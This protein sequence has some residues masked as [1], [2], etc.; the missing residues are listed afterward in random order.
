MC[1]Q[2]GEGQR[3]TTD[4]DK[5]PCSAASDC[6]TNMNSNS[7][8]DSK[9]AP[10][11]E[12]SAGVW[13]KWTYGYMGRILS[14]SFQR[15]KQRQQQQEEDSTPPLL[16]HDDIYAVPDRL[17]SQ[18]L[19]QAF[20]S[21]YKRQL[22]RQPTHER[23]LLWALWKL[24]AP[25][26]VPA[27]VCQLVSIICQ[28]AVPLIVRQLLQQVEENPAQPVDLWPCFCILA[29]L[30]VYGMTN[31][32]QRHLA[33]QAGITLR[34]TVL[35]VLYEHILTL[36]PQ[37]RA[38]VTT[39]QVTNLVAVDTQKLYEV[40]QEGHLLWALPLAILLVTICLVTILGPVSLVGIAVLVSLVPL[41]Q[42]ITASMLRLRGQRV[43]CTDERIATTHALLQGI[44][45]T[46]LNH[47]EQQYERT[48]T[49]V[50]NQEL[51]WLARETAVWATTLS[52]S[53]LSAAFAAASTFAVYVLVD[54]THILTAALSFSVFLLFSALRFP[55]NYAGRLMGRL[56][57]ARSSI[58]RLSAFL[59]RPARPWQDEDDETNEQHFIRSHTNING[60]PPLTVRQG[61][62]AIG[63]SVHSK[64]SDDSSE[65]DDDNNKPAF[66]VS[67]FDFSVEKG[68]VL[69]CCGPVGSGKS[70]LIQGILG[71]A[72]AASPATQ[73][74][75]AGS[76][77]LVPQTPF[78]LNDTV[79]ENILFGRPYDP[80]VY[81]Q[82]V[83][84]CCLGPD[85]AG[86]GPTRD[87]TE[88]GERG[89]TLSG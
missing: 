37:G 48:V 27:G 28:V 34:A 1:R 82:V 60:R 45:V 56:A 24:A 55:I 62:F 52:V 5:M 50:R 30:L 4:Q 81:Q 43:K 35:A 72:A 31:H 17:Q 53:K 25:T 84:A 6:A 7:N 18:R 65:T 71:E 58:Q 76:M 67:M 57:Q 74:F 22:P 20:W 29:V 86:L 12:D 79:R 78:I 10:W 87:L 19:R 49:T 2:G 42:R 64:E 80:I 44:Q 14:Q 41:V 89:V 68:Q 3:T 73:V 59:Q 23:A 9:A 11:P 40:A 32:R 83:Q 21:E 77:A 26:F 69:A 63:E 54:E 88:I 13:Q 47:Y 36:T 46:K 15:S 39:G 61:S 16:S 8:S 33:M 75:T 51:Q 38:G 85:M 66:V 70:T